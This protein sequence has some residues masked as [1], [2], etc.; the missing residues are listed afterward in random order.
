MA[1]RRRDPLPPWSH[2]TLLCFLYHVLKPSQSDSE[3]PHT[4]QQQID[5]KSLEPRDTQE[6]S[7]SKLLLM[8]NWKQGRGCQPVPAAIRTYHKL[9]CFKTNAYFHGSGGCKCKIKVPT[10]S[11]TGK[12]PLPGSQIASSCRVLTWLKRG[13]SSLGSF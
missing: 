6:L 11:V 8:Q 7:F 13:G 2:Q 9:G 10:D 5:S 12:T 4:V 1:E 3:S